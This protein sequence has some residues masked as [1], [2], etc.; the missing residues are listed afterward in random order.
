MNIFAS[1]PPTQHSTLILHFKDLQFHGLTDSPETETTSRPCV[2][3][4]EHTFNYICENV[5]GQHTGTEKPPSLQSFKEAFFLSFSLM[6]LHFMCSALTRTGQS[7][8]AGPATWQKGTDLFKE[9]SQGRGG[10]I[11]TLYSNSEPTFLPKPLTFQVPSVKHPGETMPAECLLKHPSQHSRQ[12]S[13]LAGT[14]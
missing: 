1:T 14:C 3:R 9:Q 6:L 10:L 13:Q 12:Q 11:G 7:L 5:T 4:T 2:L 8:K